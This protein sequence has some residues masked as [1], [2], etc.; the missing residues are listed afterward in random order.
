MNQMPSAKQLSFLEYLDC[1]DLS[2]A[3][4]SFDARLAHQNLSFSRQMA[5]K[6]SLMPLPLFSPL[7]QGARHRCLGPSNLNRNLMVEMGDGVVKQ[8]LL[9]GHFALRAVWRWA[10]EVR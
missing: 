3:K 8:V 2:P 10:L 5:W 7:A 9:M 1:V 6:Q 4:H